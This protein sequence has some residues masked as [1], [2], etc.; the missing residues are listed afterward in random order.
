MPDIFIPLENDHELKYYNKLAQ[1]GLIFR[2]AFEY[3]DKNRA[4]FQKYSGFE[5]FNK[6]F[7][8][9]AVLMN[10]FIAYAEKN[11]VEKD[12]EGQQYS[13]EKKKQ[14]RQLHTAHR[15]SSVCYR[16]NSEYKH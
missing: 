6:Q 9:T 1:S 8:V 15:S 11:G 7:M 4:V 10:E 12:I 5:D 2:F 16:P 13:Q 14:L 3:T